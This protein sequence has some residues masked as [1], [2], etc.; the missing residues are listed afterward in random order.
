MA[1]EDLRMGF[2]PAPGNLLEMSLSGLRPRN[3]DAEA[4]G[5]GPISVGDRDTW[6]CLRTTVLHQTRQ[7]GP[8]ANA[9]LLTGVAFE[10]LKT[11]FQ[12]F[13]MGIFLK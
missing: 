4:L 7:L 12:C 1:A 5:V 10:F 6:L 13:Q 8:P 2:T 11:C 3:A 9:F